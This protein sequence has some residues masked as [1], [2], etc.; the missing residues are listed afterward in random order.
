MKID[1]T[2]TGGVGGI[3]LTTTVDTE[4]LPSDEGE[5]FKK[6]VAA[7]ALFDQPEK[8]KSAGP[9]VDR[10]QYQLTAE[11]GARKKKVEM[12]E[13]AVP[14]SVQPLIDFLIERTRSAPGKKR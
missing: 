2:R 13:S 6:L 8:L 3:R 12:D 1:F 9:A 14:G 10:F 11:E 5:A 4:A 7:A